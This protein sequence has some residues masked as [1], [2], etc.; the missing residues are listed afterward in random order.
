MSALPSP[1]PTEKGNATSSAA[2]PYYALSSMRKNKGS[3]LSDD[4]VL[5]L[6][7]DSVIKKKMQHQESGAA[8]VSALRRIGTSAVL[9]I[10]FAELL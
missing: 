1:L 2:S 5:S 9:T 4:D 7:V 3:T 8:G 6:A 10:I